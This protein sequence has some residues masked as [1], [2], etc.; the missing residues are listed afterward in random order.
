MKQASALI[1][2]LAVGASAAS[3]PEAPKFDWQ[4]IAASKDLEYH[5]CYD[6][7]K[8]ARLIVPRDWKNETDPNTVTLAIA[9]LPAAVPDDDASFAGT[10]FTNP[11]GPGGS[12]VGF[13]LRGGKPLQKT[14][15]KPGKKHYEILSWDPRGIG[16]TE[17]VV[18]CFDGNTLARDAEGYTELSL[19]SIS[20]GPSALNFL[21]AKYKA[22]GGH[23]AKVMEDVLPYVNT[24]SV[25]RDM[26]EMVDKIHE[27]REREAGKK[28]PDDKDDEEEDDDRLELRRVKADKTP[29]IQYMGFSYGSVLGNYFAALFPERVGRVMLDGVVDTDDYAAGPVIIP[30][31]LFFNS[32]IISLMYCIS[33]AG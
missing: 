6:G 1:A 28:K 30:P 4:S 16:Y 14:V 7:L 23:C 22:R 19:P 31:S 11:G 15:D 17:P 32:R 5:D 3:A 13:I 9:K 2:T 20:S 18:D 8:C 27:L 21:L 12:G 10:I 33:R 24:P 26:V 29:R 25:A